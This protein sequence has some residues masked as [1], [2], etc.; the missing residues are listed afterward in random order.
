MRAVAAAKLWIVQQYNLTTLCRECPVQVRRSQQIS[1]SA[2]QRQGT[3]WAIAKVPQAIQPGFKKLK[4]GGRSGRQE[5]V[6]AGQHIRD[7]LKLHPQLEVARSG[8]YTYG[9]I[10]TKPAD[11][12][13][14]TR[15]DLAQKFHEH[16]GRK[17]GS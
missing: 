3:C 4:G 9:S 16:A 7:F 15:L 5:S 13:H 11:F 17:F 8:P 6:N 1:Y 10:F 14:S 2:D 12:G